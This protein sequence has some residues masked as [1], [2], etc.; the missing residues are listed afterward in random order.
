MLDLCVEEILDEAMKDVLERMFFIQPSETLPKD[1]G[2]AFEALLDFSGEPPGWLR[3][4]VPGGTARM[5]AADFLARDAAEVS[6][7][8]VGEVICELTN[9]ICGCLLS[10]L[11]STATFQLG[12]PRIVPAAASL[13]TAGDI[14]QHS[15][16]TASG[17]F[18]ATLMMERQ[19]CAATVPYA[20]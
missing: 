7:N 20:S 13:E 12:P 14:T 8:E 5:I 4:R 1:Q 15:L 16:V 3:L 11:E 19:P 9:M 2:P 6:Q 18:T 17:L 10:R